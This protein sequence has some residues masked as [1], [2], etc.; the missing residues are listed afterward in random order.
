MSNECVYELTV[1]IQSHVSVKYVMQNVFFS[2][3]ARY[4]S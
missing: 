3:G 4:S 1:A 2:P